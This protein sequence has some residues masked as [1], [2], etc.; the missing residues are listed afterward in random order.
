MPSDPRAENCFTSRDPPVWRVLVD[1][2]VH[3]TLEYQDSLPREMFVL[4]EYIRYYFG[5]LEYSCI[6]LP[7]MCRPCHLRLPV[8]AADRGHH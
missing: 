8:E 2:S 7:E 6:Y 5:Y 3:Y 4:D 1:I